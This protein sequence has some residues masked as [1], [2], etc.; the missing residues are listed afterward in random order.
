VKRDDF[1]T[2]P[3]ATFPLGMTTTSSHDCNDSPSNTNLNPPIEDKIINVDSTGIP[4]NS[5]CLNDNGNRGLTQLY[6][7][8]RN[9]LFHNKPRG[10]KR[11]AFTNDFSDEWIKKE[12]LD[13]IIDHYHLKGLRFFN[14]ELH[15]LIGDKIFEAI[16]SD[17]ENYTGTSNNT[18]K[19]ENKIKK[20]SSLSATNQL[21]SNTRHE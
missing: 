19:K 21:P 18:K 9:F 12:I 4:G 7:S 8:R 10:R 2:H 1:N 3:N 13:Y 20:S 11:K 15:E 17:I 6:R 16:R 5:I 14:G